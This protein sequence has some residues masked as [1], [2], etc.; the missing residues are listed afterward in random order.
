MYYSNGNYEA[1]ARPRKPQ[2]VDQKSAHLIGGGV[3]SLA[4]AAF[5][6]SDGQ[7]AGSRITVYEASS[8]TGGCLDG[9]KD[10]VEGYLSRSEREMEDHYECM[11]D[12]YRSIAS[13][14]VEGASVLDDF[15]PINKD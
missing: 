9:I 5:P 2:G 6:I 1:F 7:M 10:P 8:I 4:A 12:L 3:A 13:L 15:Y 11:W 14:D